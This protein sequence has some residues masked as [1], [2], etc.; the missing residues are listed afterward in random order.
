MLAVAAFA[1]A[2]SLSACS[3]TVGGQPVAVP[4]PSA[5][6]ASE[7]DRSWFAIPEAEAA[8]APKRSVITQT[9][10]DGATITCTAGPA[11]AAEAA[12]GHLGYVAAAHCDKGPGTVT[13]G[14]ESTAPYTG[15]I[16]GEYGATVTWGASTAT[17]TVVGGRRKVRGVLT[18]E[19]TQK[20]PYHTAVC[21]DGAVSGVQCGLLVDADGEGIEAKVDT[22]PGDSGSPMF[23]VGERGVVLIGLV[24]ESAEPFTH[25]A[26]LAPLLNKLGAVALVDQA[27]AVDTRSNPD[28]SGSVSTV[29]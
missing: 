17:P 3:S 11:V 23:L 10:P 27:T 29:Q 2:L 12:R 5:A 16:S 15:T 13:V 19:A 8:A 26:Y 18:R 9:L 22:V 21:V 20:L 1:A 24:E 6:Q 25:A 4:S 28:Y 7:A 14:R